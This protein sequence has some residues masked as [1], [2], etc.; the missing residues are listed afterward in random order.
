MKF[1]QTMH[2]ITPPPYM[3]WPGVDFAFY[4]L[5]LG[6]NNEYSSGMY[7]DKDVHVSQAAALLDD[8]EERMFQVYTER[9]GIAELCNNK[10]RAETRALALLRSRLGSW[11]VCLRRVVSV[12]DN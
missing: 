5:V 7:A 4:E 12:G 1:L 3:Y 10:E 8:A 11:R 9:A 2:L 6:S